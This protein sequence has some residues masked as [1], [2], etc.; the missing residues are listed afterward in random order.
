VTDD[1]R[2]RFLCD[3]ETGCFEFARETFVLI[4]Q[5]DDNVDIQTGAFRITIDVPAKRSR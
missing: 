1:V 4:P 5:V 2:Q 3:A